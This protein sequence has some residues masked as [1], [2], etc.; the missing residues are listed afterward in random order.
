MDVLNDVTLSQALDFVARL[1]LAFSILNAILPPYDV[2]EGFPGA[3]RYYKLFLN[4][5][6]YF[7]FDMR[8]KVVALY[9]SFNR[10]I[11]GTAVKEQK[12]EDLKQDVIDIK[13]E[14]AV[15]E[16][17]PPAEKKNG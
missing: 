14:I 4:I 9:P 6:R 12:V 10:S 13:K 17:P 15:V 16:A 5:V 2:L 8:S 7:A 1:C 11:I 3:Q